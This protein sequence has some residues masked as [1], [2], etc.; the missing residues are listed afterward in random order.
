MDQKVF[1]GMLVGMGMMFV[2]LGFFGWFITGHC[3][4]KLGKIF[5]LVGIDASRHYLIADLNRITRIYAGFIVT[6]VVPLFFGSLGIKKKVKSNTICLVSLLVLGST[7]MFLGLINWI[8]TSFYMIGIIFVLQSILFT[9]YKAHAKYY[10]PALLICGIALVILGIR[11]AY[12]SDFLSK[13]GLGVLGGGVV[14]LVGK[15]TG[16]KKKMKGADKIESC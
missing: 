10:G 16:E 3:L 6:G 13:T 2:L 15:N 9:K 7:Y 4:E 1:N 12:V 14:T 11:L 5:L 8:E